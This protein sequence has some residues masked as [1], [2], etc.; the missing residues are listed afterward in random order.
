[1]PI[2]NPTGY[3]NI[4]VMP[5]N[6]DGRTEQ[7]LYVGFG[8]CDTGCIREPTKTTND[9]KS[10]QLGAECFFVNLEDFF[11]AGNK[12]DSDGVCL[13]F[14]G[15]YGRKDENNNGQYK[16][17][18]ERDN[19]FNSTIKLSAGNHCLD[20]FVIRMTYYQ[21][22]VDNNHLSRVTIITLAAI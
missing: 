4:L 15:V 5:T 13:V 17:L 2:T 19:A 21:H 1:M 20:A 14:F 6:A 10:E 8:D 7:D 18:A 12:V 3:L 11:A 16:I 22:L 9:A